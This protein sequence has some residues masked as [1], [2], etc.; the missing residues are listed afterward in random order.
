MQS[1]SIQIVL[2]QIALSVICAVEAWVD[3]FQL[4]YLYP[5]LAQQRETLCELMLSL[6]SHLRPAPYPYGLLCLRLLGKPVL[7][8]DTLPRELKN[9]FRSTLS[10]FNIVVLQVSWE[11]KIASSCTK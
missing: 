11:E 10:T 2:T 8:I 6:A 1:L 5:I 3:S 9:V 7:R 4:D